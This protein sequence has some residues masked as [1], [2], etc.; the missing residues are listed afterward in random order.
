MSLCGLGLVVVNDHGHQL[1][2]HHPLDSPISGIDP[3]G[4]A[5]MCVP[6]HNSALEF[7]LDHRRI[8][9]YPAVQEPT[10]LL[11]VVL[12][13]GFQTSDP[14]RGIARHLAAA[15]RYEQT[16]S[17]YVVEQVNA[18]L[19][20]QLEETSHSEIISSCRLAEELAQL[21]TEITCQSIVSVFINNTI[22][23]SYTLHP[24][25]P[26]P[27][28]PYHA[29]L[30]LHP[31]PML[32]SQLPHDASPIL[33]S[34]IKLVTP[35]KSLAEVALDAG[36]SIH[37]ARSLAEHLIHWGKATSIKALNKHAVY[38]ANEPATV[39][40]VTAIQSL[41][42]GF[43]MLFPTH[44]LPEI[45]SRFSSHKIL[46]DQLQGLNSSAH[47]ELL[48]I[49][50]YLLQRGL[51]RR[52]N[53]YFYLIKAGMVE[54]DENEVVGGRNRLPVLKRK[55]YPVFRKLYKYFDGRHDLEEII[56]ATGV[57]RTDLSLVVSEYIDVMIACHR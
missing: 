52:L 25:A 38:I 50:V 26:G 45:L 31:A 22:H 29:L 43:S 19:K 39:D 48:R 24:V 53:T 54:N 42:K 41:S 5:R 34:F 36:I 14:I 40:F 21:Y 27:L 28:E 4:F 17:N 10:F 16:A 7:S 15:L 30:L 46:K 57:S 51:L 13:T 8:L 12:M 1:V 2:F 55:S 35:M 23:V 20:L 6:K 11:H 49:V 9:S 37:T 47:I 44:S 32:I 33:S 18:I 3:V 56:S